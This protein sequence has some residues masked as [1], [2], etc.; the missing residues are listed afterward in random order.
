MKTLGKYEV[1]EELGA[2]A[3][4][5]VFHGRDRVLQRDVAIKTIS[6][7]DAD[8]E[9]KQRFYREA[10][11]C[12]RLSHPNIVT[13]F[14]LGEQQGTSYIAMEYLEGEDLRKFI[15][16]KNFM[17]LEG[18]LQ[19]MAEVA[20]GLAH[21]HDNRIVHRD[22][23]PSNIFLLKSGR[24]KLLDFGIARVFASQLTRVGN[25]LGTPEYMAPEQIRGKETDARSDIFSTA[26][27]FFELLT[28][29]HPFGDA[30]IPRKIIQESPK[31]LRDLNPLIP[32]KLEQ[33]L[34]RAMAKDPAERYQTAAEFAKA[35]RKLSFEILGNCD[36][37][38]TEAL[39]NRQRIL[40]SLAVVAKAG[41]LP[42]IQ[43]KMVQENVDASVVGKINP[44]MA[45]TTN[46]SLHY[47]SLCGLTRDSAHAA[48]ILA[49]I[50]GEHQRISE[51][52]AQARKLFAD[53]DVTG[54]AHALGV[55]EDRKSD[56]PEIEALRL[57]IEKRN[58]K[59]AEA[60]KQEPRKSDK[61]VPPS[62]ETIVMTGQNAKGENLSPE[63]LAVRKRIAA[64]LEE[65]IDKCLAEI[66]ILSPAMANDSVI[67]S[68]WVRALS[69]RSAQQAALAAAR[70]QTPISMNEK[71]E[72]R[73]SN[74]PTIIQAPS[75]MS[76]VYETSVDKTM[77]PEP[78]EPYLVS[79]SK[80]VNI[81][82]IGG[83]AAAGVV[84]VVVGL[85]TFKG[86]AGQP[87]GKVDN[88]VTT[89]APEA[90][91][92]ISLPPQRQ[93]KAPEAV[94]ETHKQQIAAP[95]EPSQPGQ[96]AERQR[97]PPQVDWSQELR[98]AQ[99]AFGDGNY[100]TAIGLCDKILRAQPSNKPASELKQ[101]AMN[102][103]AFEER[104][105]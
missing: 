101:R 81:K 10:R 93:E 96:S 69:I 39:E 36:R 92:P 44:E 78:A 88:V 61:V 26:V 42:W 2:G 53:G 11:S 84:L 29:E 37:L 80:Q 82:W 89:P 23:K 8:V 68:Y 63:L 83:I 17:P 27:V 38:I 76:T 46:A 62:P 66:E 16:R 48:K 67:D 79:L 86:D 59:K 40:D 103:K 13:V 64:L 34:K 5:K 87:D 33:I 15:D 12:G 22:I 58:T 72:T 74:V 24:P 47:F 95:A 100:D 60:E 73:P 97:R 98:A 9:L 77:Q 104:F 43:N 20:E 65:D 51:T 30:D 70:L 28:Y 71:P 49:E 94:V 4:G 31:L 102:A 52:L 50:A 75:E 25:A 56:Y 6:T 85:Y 90:P 35:L 21:A 19:V 1:L 3:M 41:A 99:A 91:A 14:D 18:K 45:R 32:E 105:K 54:A 7:E 55:C 57:D